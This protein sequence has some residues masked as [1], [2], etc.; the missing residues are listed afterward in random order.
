MLKYDW[1]PLTLVHVGHAFAVYGR[2]LPFISGV[3]RNHL[4]FPVVIISWEG[5]LAP[6]DESVAGKLL[7]NWSMVAPKACTTIFFC[8]VNHGF[9][10]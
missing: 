6:A 8:G 3:G 10:I 1:I 2:E 7:K 5:W 9:I 4:L